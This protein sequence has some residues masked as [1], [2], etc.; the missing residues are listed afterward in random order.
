MHYWIIATY[1]DGRVFRDLRMTKKEQLARQLTM[2][3]DHPDAMVMLEEEF[4]DPNAKPT[5]TGD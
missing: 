5:A 1:R 2:M 3:E 4:K